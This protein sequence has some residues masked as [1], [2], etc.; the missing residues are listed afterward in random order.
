[1]ATV[2]LG[3]GS[4]HSPQLSSGP[5]WWPGHAQRDRANPCLLGTDGIEYTYADLEARL[6]DT[7]AEELTAEMWSRKYQRAQDAVS[8]LAKRL[9]EAAP[10]VVVIV[11]DDQRELFEDDVN[12]AIGLFLGTQLIDEGMTDERVARLPEDI[13]PAQWAAHARA[14]DVYLV[15][16]ELSHHVAAE[17]SAADFDVGVFS[18]QLPGRTLGHAFTF[19]RHRLGVPRSVPIVPVILNTYYPPNVPTP[20]RCWCLGGAIRQA[21]ESWDAERRVAFVASGGLTH[22]V[23]S[24]ELDRRV[25]AVLSGGG[26]QEAGALPRP[27]LRS[28][29]SEILNWLVVGG[30]L[31]DLEFEVIDYVPA[32]RSAAGTGVGLGFAIWSPGEVTA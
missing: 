21:V 5:E 13:L 24:E 10:D 28:G 4:S 20:A 1:M 12:P 18:S 32:Y 6:G 26:E 31:A 25:L 14:A 9:E 22:F 17:L 2:V 23:V 11:G 19:A 27:A 8:T 7:L 29:S 15:D 16:K 30:A 3:V